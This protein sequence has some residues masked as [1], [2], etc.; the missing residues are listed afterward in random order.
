MDLGI[1]L[2]GIG[3]A[4]GIVAG[5]AFGGLLW[6]VLLDYGFVAKLERRVTSLENSIKGSRGADAREEKAERMSAAVAEG[7]AMLHSGIE[8]VEIAKTLAPKYPDIAGKL[9]KE[10]MGGKLGL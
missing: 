7:A 9:L 1:I 4:I 2:V 6:R 10:F 5:S 8:P 3:W